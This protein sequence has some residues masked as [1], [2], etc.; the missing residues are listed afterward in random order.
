[1]DR[2]GRK[3]RA[4]ALL[5]GLGFGLAGAAGEAT[6]SLPLTIPE[7]RYHFQ[8]PLGDRIR[9]NTEQWLL[10]APAANPGMLEMFRQRDRTPPPRLVPW[11]GEFVGKYLLSAIQALRLTDDPRLEPFVAAVVADL[12]ATQAED[13]YLGPFPH[14]ERL[15]GQ[16][17]LWGHY[18]AIQALALWYE[19]RRDRAALECACRAA[20]LICATCLDGPRRVHDAGSHEMNMAVIHGLGM[21]YRI[22][23]TERYLR[24]MREIEKDWEKPPAGDYLRTGLA[25][26][27][28]FR[29]PKPR[30]ESLHDLQG[31]AE[32]WQITGDERYRRAFVHHWTSIRD[33][34][35]H[36]DGGFTTGEQAV[37]NPYAPGAVETCC[38][39]AWMTL[40]VDMLRLTGDPAA[41]D[42][43]ELSTWNG[44]LGAQH[45]SGR[46]WTYNTPL[47][48]VREASAHTIVF[49]ARAGTPELNCCSVNGPRGLGL[50]GQWGVMLDARGPVVNL[51]APCEVRLNLPGEAALRLRQETAYPAEGAVRL[52]VGLDEGPREF[53]LSLRVPRWSATTSVRVNGEPLRETV[54]PGTYLALS[55]RWADG[56]T[57]ELELDMSF[58]HWSGELARQGSAA[59]YRGPLLLAFDQALNPVD[60]AAVPPLDLGAPLA[61]EPVAVSSPY[62][63]LTAFRVTAADG[64]RLLLCDFATAGARGT[65]YRAWLPA[66][67]GLPAPFHLRRPLPG[68]R[69]PAGPALFEWTGYRSSAAAGRTF[70]LEVAE[71]PGFAKPI[72]RLE[73][74]AATRA[75]VREGLLPGRTYHWRVTALNLCG[76]TPCQDPP[77]AFTVDAALPQLPEEALAE[78]GPV[79][80]DGVMLRAPL[81][82]TPVPAI[83]ALESAHGLTPA[84]DRHGVPGKALAFDG[85]VSRLTYRIPYFPEGDC[86]V[87]LWAC[88]E[89]LPTDRLHELFSAWAAGMDDPLRLVISG[90]EVFARIEA[91]AAY[92]TPGV[93]LENGR[94]YAL[95][96]VK[97]GA[98]LCLYVD[99]RMRAAAEVPASVFSGAGTVGVGC[100][101]NYPGNERFAGRIAGVAL[102]ARALTERE[103]AE[104]LGLV[105][106][107]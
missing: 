28:F 52:T 45:P 5:A 4:A 62:P 107:P 41:A 98:R 26:T 84:A 61:A 86:T 29:S 11:A 73:S 90:R 70:R 43:L 51:Y 93:P 19:Y 50:L 68:E 65:P 78:D 57:V 15:L 56:D 8:G 40:C 66:R 34:D 14:G 97:Q 75:V 63:P 103:L 53:T 27:E 81:E 48:G 58:R 16:W 76:E 21:L 54:S 100:N 85:A 77:R 7:A 95:A 83:G 3:R 18:H 17:D 35:R 92:G 72:V 24:L 87:L 91:G 80:P 96:A 102:Y 59:L 106:E 46:W 88:P 12:I 37:G 69:V 79:G 22:T 25:G 89:A 23:G 32:L 10:Q 42:E 71:A 39:V 74:I 67:A 36:P 94:W 9:A 1:M 20:D 33:F 101:P 30:W 104:A 38:T 49:Q 82:G 60:A 47:D 99:G 105:T 2:P 44:L 13:G 6:M 64:R 55:R 31:L